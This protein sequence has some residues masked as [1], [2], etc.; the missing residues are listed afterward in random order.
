L[1]ADFAEVGGPK[2]SPRSLRARCFILQG[3]LVPFTALTYLA[4]RSGS[5]GDI[6]DRP[7]ILTTLW[8]I[9]GP[10]VGAI[11]RHGQSCC[12]LLSLKLAAICGPIL[13]VGVMGQVVALPFGRGQQPVRLLLWT[14]GW[15][16]WLLGGPASLLHAFK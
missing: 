2:Q 5:P 6:G 1:D 14:I 3:L 4:V 13:A 15:L 9:S 11:A 10:F 7:V 12:L 8:T 16:A